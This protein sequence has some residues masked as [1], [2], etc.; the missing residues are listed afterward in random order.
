MSKKNKR[1]GRAR[2]PQPLEYLLRAGEGV[3]YGQVCW[4]IANRGTERPRLGE[5]ITLEVGNDEGGHTRRA[6]RLTRKTIENIQ[7]CLGMRTCGEAIGMFAEERE[8]ESSDDP[9]GE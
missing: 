6:F 2:E 4:S 7:L 3:L 9:M 5:V 8:A 1:K